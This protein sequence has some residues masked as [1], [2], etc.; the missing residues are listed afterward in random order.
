MAYLKGTSL[1]VELHSGSLVW[2]SFW[3]VRLKSKEDVILTSVIS[4]MCMFI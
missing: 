1:L 2:S 3:Q 4:V